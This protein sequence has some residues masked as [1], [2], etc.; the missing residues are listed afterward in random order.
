MSR[1]SLI[2]SGLCSSFFGLALTTPAGAE[3]L[4][5]ECPPKYP[6]LIQMEAL[7][8]KGWIAPFPGTP[9]APLEQMSVSV[10]PA[11][12]NGELRG[13]PVRGGAGERFPFDMFEEDLE[14]WVFCGYR[15]PS[16]YA[17]LMYRIPIGGQACVTRLK[18]A[19]GRLVAA[20]IRCE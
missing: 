16:G 3:P 18:Q 7:K 11:E 13:D 19:H 12:R 1:T 6:D 4:V 17:R 8:V 2:I 5:L 15:M 20:N 10:G 14:K 9:S